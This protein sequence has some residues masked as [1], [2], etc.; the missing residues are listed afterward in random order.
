M[1]NL[2]LKLFG[3]TLKNPVMNASGTLGYGR[4]IEPLWGVERLGAYVTKGLS[5]KPHH[6]NPTPRVWEER[7]GMINS[8]GLQNIGIE[9]FFDEHFPFFRQK[10]TPI[11]VN[12]FGFTEDEYIACAERIKPHRLIIALEM[13]LSCPNVKKGGISF[14]KEASTVY[15][16]VKHVKSATK[17]PLLAKL[18][19]EVK[20]IV[21]IA[22]A[23][24]EAGIDG[25]TL[26][27]TIPA[28]VVDTEKKNIPIK[29]GL[30]GPLLK[31]IALKAVHEISKTIPLPV[32]GTGGI[33]NHMDAIAFLMAGARA[34]QVGTATFV[35]PYTIP[36][37]I[38]GISE[39]LDVHGYPKIEDIIGIAHG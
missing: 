22:Q 5:L 25:F 3:K 6:G 17:I 12:F 21:E 15:D 37:I 1:G 30:S 24:Y 31:P 19:P 10:K 11:I 29:G 2:S 9:R 28:V 18:T 20:N 13:N 35:D 36:K 26:L 16:I 8:I 23:A 39:Y 32:I 27:N 4:E 38:E 33:M 34:I 14:G 7:C